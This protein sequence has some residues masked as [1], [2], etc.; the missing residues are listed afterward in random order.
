MK[1]SIKV[2]GKLKLSYYD[3]DTLVHEE[4]HDNLVVNVG[5]NL[6]ATGIA[7][8]TTTAMSHLA[9]GTSTT[10]ASAAQTALVT[11]VARV[12]L[13]ST[14]RTN[15]VIVYV[16]TIPAGT[17]TGTITEA[18]LFSASSG[19]SMFSRSVFDAKAKLVTNSLVVTWTIT[20]GAA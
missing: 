10:A 5:L 1:D 3:N 17:G 12:A 14:T 6:L 16:A 11:E 8:G 2:S 20:I 13:T 4:E 7:T 19:G 15:N 9:I 18:G